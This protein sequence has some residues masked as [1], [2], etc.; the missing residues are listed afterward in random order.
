MQFI[1]ELI[2]KEINIENEELAKLSPSAQSIIKETHEKLFCESLGICHE[3]FKQKN[4]KSY[5]RSEDIR[6]VL[7]ILGID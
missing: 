4:N 1:Y 7:D 3:D 2:T 6:N 5:N